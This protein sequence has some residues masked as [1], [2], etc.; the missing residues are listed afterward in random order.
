METVIYFIRHAQSL[1]KAYIHRPNW[2]DCPLS[3][4][5]EKQAILLS[6]IV[7]NLG[8]EHVVSSPYIR[9]V[10]TIKPFVETHKIPMTIHYDIRERHLSHS[11]IDEF[12][13]FWVKSW[14]DFNF[15]IPGCESSFEA[16]ER[17]VKAIQEIIATQ[18]G[19]TIVIITHGN[20]LGLFLNY[21]N[22]LN[23]R[24]EAERLQNPDILRMIHRDSHFHWDRDFRAQGLDDMASNRD[25]TPLGE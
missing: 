15:K 10:N 7:L 3:E 23:H 21:I 11:F 16:Q 18:Q 17:F 20:V 9:C 24:E 6:D 2:F 13:E 19:K 22:S 8:I 12:Y 25:Q 5:G 4:L 1:P 14:E